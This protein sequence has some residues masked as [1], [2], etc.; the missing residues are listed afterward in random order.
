MNKFVMK[1]IVLLFVFFN[2]LSGIA[3]NYYWVGGSGNWTD[4]SHWS[5]LS[6]GSGGSFFTPPSTTSRVFFDT[7]SFS[8]TGH[9]VTVDTSHISIKDMFW[10]TSINGDI[11]MPTFTGVSA[12]TITVN[13]SL[14]LD[15]NMIYDFNGKFFMTAG[16]LDT[17][18]TG[19][20]LL[21]NDFHISHFDSLLI[22]ADNFNSLGGLTFNRGGFKITN[23]TI[24]ARFFKSKK[25]N[26]RTLILDNAVF[27]LA[28]ND[29][30][31]YIN[32]TSL[33]K[34]GTSEIFNILNSTPDTVKIYMGKSV[35]QW[36][37]LNLNNSHT[38]FISGAN[39][40]TIQSTTSK[41]IRLKYNDTLKSPNF[42]VSGNCG[43]ILN[44][45]CKEGVAKFSGLGSPITISYTSIKN[46][47]GLSSSTYSASNSFNLGGN[48][49]WTI[50][51]D[52]GVN[53]FHWIGGSGSF[54]NPSMWSTISGGVAGLCFPGP[55]DIAIFDANSTLVDTVYI[56]RK[57]IIGR[58]DFQNVPNT[59]VLSGDTENSI[60]V[61][62]NLIGSNLLDF[63]WQGSLYLTASSDTTNIT[64]NGVSWG[65]KIFKTG[66]STLTFTD[67]FTS[68][69]SFS[70][71]NGAL[72]GNS[73][74]LSFWNFYADSTN[75]ARNIN[76]G[77]SVVDLAGNAYKIGAIGTYSTPKELN[78]VNADGNYVTF[79]SGSYVYDTIRIQTSNI[80]F[81]TDYTSQNVTCSLLEINAG[82]TVLFQNGSN[83]LFDSI[84]AIGS[85]V[86]P[87]TFKTNSST[88]S[89]AVVAKT[90]NVN[91]TVEH[92]IIDN[93]DADGVG[94]YFA[95]YSTLL[96]GSTNWTLS[97]GITTIT[98]PLGGTSIDSNSVQSLLGSITGFTPAIVFSSTLYLDGLS[99][100]NSTDLD[101]VTYELTVDSGGPG[102][103]VVMDSLSGT[104]DQ[105]GV[106]FSFPTSIPTGDANIRLILSNI[107]DSGNVVLTNS[108]I[109]I[110]YMA[111]LP[112]P[113]P[114]T[115]YW[116]NDGGN[117]SDLNHWSTISGDT[118]Y[119]T[120]VPSVY[121]NVIFDNN[122][123]SSAHE[124]VTVDKEVYV[125]SMSWILTDQDSATLLLDKTMTFLGDVSLNNQVFATRNN[126]ATKMIFQPNGIKT[127]DAT[128]SL[129]NVQ[130][131]LLS[132]N[133][134]NQIQLTSDLNMSDSTNIIIGGGAFKTMN[135]NISTGTLYFGSPT[136]KLVDLGTSIVN[137]RYGFKDESTSSSLNLLASLSTI[138]I[139]F[140]NSIDSIYDNY[141]I[142]TGHIFND[143]SLN[144]NF[145][146]YS[147]IKGNNTFHN[148][149]VGKGSKLNITA[150]DSLKITNQFTAIGTCKDS[151]Y[152]KST[153]SGLDF[154][155]E[156]MTT[157]STIECVNL[158]DV[159][160]SDQIVTANYSTNISA[161]G[162][163][164]F[165]ATPAASASFG[166]ISNFCLGDTVQL[167]SNSSATSGI[168][169]LE[170]TFDDTTYVN[171]DTVQYFYAGP[172]DYTIELT[173]I[174]ANFCSSKIDTTI[175][176]LN[177]SVVLNSSLVL[178]T[179]ICAGESVSFFADAYPDTNSISYQFYINSLASVINDTLFTTTINNLDTIS[180]SILQDACP[181]SSNKFVFKVDPLPIPN[182]ILN[183][184]NIICA[185]DSVTLTATGG[186]IYQ[187][188]KNGTAFTTF[189]ATSVQTM[190][191]VDNGDS[192]FVVVKNSA[193][194]C[195]INSD[196]IAFTVNTL[197]I[198]TF[199]DNDPIT[200]TICQG[201]SVTFISSTA[202]PGNI[203][204]Y[205]YIINNQSWAD[206]TLSSFSTTS[207]DDGDT[208]SVVVRDLNGCYSD[209]S[210][211]I[212]YTVNAIPTI[213]VTSNINSFC[214]GELATFTAT[215]GST[216]EFLLNGDTLQVMSGQSF[217]TNS[218]IL[219]GDQITVNGVGNN[220]PSTSA[221][222]IMTVLPLPVN[223]LTSNIGSIICS[224]QSP[225]F[226]S[227][228]ALATSF[229]FIVNGATVQASSTLAT[230]S[231][232]S[233]LPDGAIVSVVSYQGSCSYTSYLTMTI[234]QS[235]VTSIYTNDFDNS[236]CSNGTIIVTATGG[237]SFEFFINNNSQGITTN[238]A[239]TI[240]GSSLLA[241]NNVVYV[242]VIG[243]NTCE[244]NTSLVNIEMVQT[245]T[246]NMTSSAALNTSCQ[247]IPVTFTATA[248]AANYQFFLDGTSLGLP[249][250]SNTYV[251]SSLGNG[252]VITLVGYNGACFNSSADTITMSIDPNP[253][254]NISG[255]AVFCQGSPAIFEGEQGSQY[256]F[257]LDGNSN[258][259]S[260]DSIFSPSSLAVGN[261]VLAL[262][263]FQNGCFASASKNLSVISLPVATLTG[264]S[265]LCSGQTVSFL[266]GGA[267]QYMFQ[268]NGINTP[269]GFSTNP[270]FSG[271]FNNGDVISVV[272]KNIAT[273]ESVNLNALILTVNPTP[274]VGLTSNDPLNDNITCTNDILDFTATGANS[275][276]FMINGFSQGT[277]SA[278]SMFS[279]STLTSGQIVSVIGTSLNCASHTYYAP[280]S[281]SG[282]P[283]VQLTNN[284]DT[285]LCVGENSNLTASGASTYLYSINNV[286]QGFYSTINNFNSALNNG[287]IITVQGQTNTCVS[288]SPPSITYQVFNYPSTSLASSTNPANNI[289]CFGDTVTFTG[290]GATNYE[291]FV[292]G[293][294][295][296]S[297]NGLLTL[298]NLENGQVVSLIGANDQCF[299]SAP[300][301]IAFT[302]NT[303]DI[304]T[305]VTPSNF[306]I[307]S[308][309]DLLLSATGSDVYSILINGI[310][311]ALPS[312]TGNFTLSNL[313]AGD[314]I[315]LSGTN[316]TTGCIQL[317]DETIYVQVNA[318][319]DFTI[320]GS[321]T[322]CE[323]DSTILTSN[324][325][326][327]NQWLLN[328]N[329]ILG[330]N[331]QNYLVFTS[332]NYSLETSFGGDFDMWSF[333]NNSNGEFGNGAN[334]NSASPVKASGIT[335]LSKIETGYA[336]LIG[337]DNSGLVYTW[338]TNSSGQLGN[339]TYTAANVPIQV[340]AVPNA[341]AVSAGQDFSIAVSSAGNLF[342]WGGNNSGQLGLN[343]LTTFSNPQLVSSVNNVENVACG[344]YHTLLLKSNG[345][346][347]ASGNNN[348]GQ[349]GIGNLISSPVFAPVAGLTNI[350]HIEAGDY[351]SMAI[352]NLGQLYV[353]GNNSNGQLGLNDLSNRLQPALSP[354]ENV[355]SCSGGNAH[356]LIVTTNGKAYTCGKNNFGQ[357]AT[358][359]LTN[360]DSPTLIKEIDAVAEVSAGGYHSL[361]R[362]IDGS[363]WGAGRNDNFQL[364][365][366]TSGTIL[367]LE[368]L[369]ELAGVTSIA[370]GTQNSHF[371][372]GNSITCSAPASVFNVSSAPKPTVVNLNSQMV[373]ATTGA[374]YH[375][376]LN[377]IAI[378]NSN[379]PSVNIT[380]N[381]Y[382]S[383]G[384]TFANGCIRYSD[385]L[386][387][388]ITGF[389][390]EQ[391]TDFVVYPNPF[392]EH[393]TIKGTV[394][395]VRPKIYITDLQGRKI[396]E[397]SVDAQIEELS[398]DLGQYANGLY[399]LSI[400]DN[401]GTI[402]KT[403]IIKN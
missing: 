329:T 98:I 69:K 268:V 356:T 5:N 102:P 138:N 135:K 140:D 36:N 90:S 150:G 272:G 346:V 240:N 311:P 96:N 148:L 349:L 266:A 277:S 222:L 170:W 328:G 256:E 244:T 92:L 114:M 296:P 236:I 301:P 347:L 46:I 191:D 37:T 57:I 345:T 238:S 144:F 316:N 183:N 40:N 82:S 339:G 142:S 337:L 400:E 73:S 79:V 11:D 85:C 197:P 59:V 51:E 273:C 220:C 233:T 180:V 143:V 263:V 120:C 257:I 106:S 221:P 276:E 25:S 223:T 175:S 121:D 203:T 293:I 262:N 364:S 30:V 330:A 358:N 32:P 350:V 201:D 184:S 214:A 77:S 260:T 72:N 95:N 402:F 341:I 234:N 367:M 127:F 265:V 354:L 163:F 298:T 124:V 247:G 270:S 319:V 208:V 306:M 196:T 93:V 41:S 224:S 340:L 399:Q 371:I 318:P 388:G 198:I 370:A 393:I 61:R 206:T 47:R 113:I 83:Y 181:A 2:S 200:N 166:S 68:L 194:S 55:N 100:S 324:A 310:A 18:Y 123:F 64:S 357:L 108:Y 300:N 315:V 151:I 128:G 342:A 149:S 334:F 294:S 308:G 360:R 42:L 325:L 126:K 336:H 119:A 368:R 352:D 58:L 105:T 23:R 305:Q 189:S 323:G 136:S 288:I 365:T 76:F 21:L 81:I 210:N 248:T 112:A 141:F 54:Y 176:I 99:T 7:N 380:A 27:N 84:I 321:Q 207:L 17:L 241:G 228:S 118:S 229:E 171:E 317:D 4:T 139:N 269:S 67:D 283:I 239:L 397:T 168:P 403:N 28:G 134:I 285:T 94:N 88:A 372:Y 351:H 344:K 116:V 155:I 132:D 1:L 192:F 213:S 53:T 12:D 212:I 16:Q 255:T 282:Y 160:S 174:N 281:V 91:T 50:T 303:M 382:Y 164:A 78:F 104:G 253:V 193:T 373:T 218:T 217:Y 178:D 389:G 24:N 225:T 391:L 137:L 335:D 304:Q 49:A 331:D 390:E 3:Q 254:A 130:I 202:I 369:T 167:I 275:Y 384:I 74:N 246:V 133:I 185:G 235:P 295:I 286:P 190:T 29:T 243:V 392:R 195:E 289:I 80:D 86:E 26:P 215:G 312:A 9:I 376:Y 156:K 320:D 146:N 56:S 394:L 374:S 375:W 227:T 359:D 348:F 363:V 362:K 13:G 231:P 22:L 314:F 333:G 290:G 65:C 271:Q 267:N 385:E 115:Y 209:T 89:P 153:D 63:D 395:S 237:S 309:T 15:D 353:W 232:L 398:I 381:G 87:I 157:P 66:A 396:F 145:E 186:S 378:I 97:T 355:A 258:G 187:F 172:G 34:T 20:N 75:N 332:G 71:V 125:N 152:F 302:V 284:D 322:F 292:D 264:S 103:I 211:S 122:S 249:S 307:C 62:E 261:H 179:T 387:Y 383:V 110:N 14:F 252:T 154:I 287:D 326:N 165:S 177:P 44:F 43:S 205:N 280:F 379:A 250:P 242:K 338:G 377:G 109:V 117:W 278:N 60:E 297:T 182:L 230:Y 361:F 159:K 169:S 162:A 31:L 251:S 226:T 216:Y 111:A 33:I 291:Y 366:L 52:P 274:V 10:K 279:T 39:F 188:Y 401:A 70:H 19:N 386:G 8:G 147:N 161:T 101:S 107:N 219:N 204:R 6:G 327:G 245:P 199:D 48:T 38:Y 129:V 158:T 173:A 343:N 35:S 259:I 299:T 131:V 45:Y 313:V